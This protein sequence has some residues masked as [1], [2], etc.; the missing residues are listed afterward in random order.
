MVDIEQD[1]NT[2]GTKP[3]PPAEPADAV[4]APSSSSRDAFL[5]RFDRQFHRVEAYVARR[6]TE[7]MRRR[8]VAQVFASCVDVLLFTGDERRVARAL[9]RA[10]DRF[11]ELAVR[12]APGPGS[13]IDSERR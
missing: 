2:I 10:S 6:T 3:G 12:H 1:T 7:P 5:R 13:P 11:L 8:I 9:K 4:G